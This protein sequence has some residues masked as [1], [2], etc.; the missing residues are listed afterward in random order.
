MTAEAQETVEDYMK[1]TEYL[2]HRAFTEVMAK[3]LFSPQTEKLLKLQANAT[4]VLKDEEEEEEP[5]AK[6]VQIEGKQI[7]ESSDG[8]ADITGLQVYKG[9]K[10]MNEIE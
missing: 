2:K 7:D 4:F 1:V 3:S 9:M 10:Q 5:N 6:R 8:E